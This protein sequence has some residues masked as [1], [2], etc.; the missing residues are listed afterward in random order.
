MEK[1]LEKDKKYLMQTYTRQP[2]VLQSGKGAVIRDINGKKYIDCV[3][4][5]AVNNVG[6]CHPKIVKAIQKQV[7]KLIHISNLYYCELQVELAEQLVNLTK[8]DKVFFCNTGTEAVE[9]ALKLAR[10]STGKTD[11]I[12]T[13][14]SF[15]GRTLGALSVTY[16]E[17][18]RKPYEPL[19]SGVTFVPYNDVNAISEKMTPKTCAVILEPIQGESGV[20]VPSEYYLKEVSEICNEKGILLILDEVQTGFGRTGK[21]FAKEHYKVEPD[22]MTLAKAIG[23]GFPIGATLAKEN[24]AKEFKSGDHGSTFAGNPLACAS[25][26]SA[27]EAIKEE[28]LVE[29]SAELGEYFINKLKAIQN[30]DIVE[31]R[32]KGLMIGMELQQVAGGIVDNAIQEGVLLNCITDKVL[33]FVPPLVITKEQID[34]VVEVVEKVIEYCTTTPP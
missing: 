4:G 12:A 17:Q 6:H 28:K 16:K 11:F 2:I 8:M 31:V 14:G 9:A 7:E 27:I 22:I 19:I 32:G 3:A 25:A 26:L 1:I 10:K 33:R 18:Y 24:I 21:W 15:H 30:P 5:I 20:I 13:V 34:K 29:K 23:G